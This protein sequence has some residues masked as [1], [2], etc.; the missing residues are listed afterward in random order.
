VSGSETYTY[1]GTNLHRSSAVADE[2]CRLRR[3]PFE[4][5]QFFQGARPFRAK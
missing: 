1:F 3:L 2:R 4:S 5:L